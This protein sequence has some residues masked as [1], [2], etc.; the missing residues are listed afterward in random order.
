MYLGHVGAE[1]SGRSKSPLEWALLGAGLV[2][3]V[4]AALWIGRM[5]RSHLEQRSGSADSKGKHAK[6]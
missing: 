5:A 1:A 6:K 2:A 4:V 3:S